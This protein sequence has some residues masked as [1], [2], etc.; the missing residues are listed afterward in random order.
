M[1]MGNVSYLRIFWNFLP[2]NIIVQCSGIFLP[3]PGVKF[4]VVLIFIII[5]QITFLFKCEDSSIEW[6]ENI[7]ECIV[8]EGNLTMLP[9]LA[10]LRSADS[11]VMMKSLPDWAKKSPDQCW[12][13]WAG[14]ICHHRGLIFHQRGHT[15][16]YCNYKKNCS[17]EF[18]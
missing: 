10:M 16:T 17:D 8:H 11:S 5:V 14:L 1:E 7:L 2:T 9:V 12:G 15:W 6:S 3:L 13:S 4:I 18:A